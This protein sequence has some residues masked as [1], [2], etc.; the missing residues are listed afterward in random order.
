MSKQCSPPTSMVRIRVD[1]L[2]LLRRLS[3]ET[4]LSQVQLVSA[5]VEMAAPVIAAGTP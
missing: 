3:D 4:G 5:A 1:A 2:D